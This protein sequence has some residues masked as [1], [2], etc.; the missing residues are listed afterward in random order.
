[1]LPDERI[2]LVG[3]IARLK[4]VPN[5][6]GNVVQE[7]SVLALAAASYGA[8]PDPN[9]T[10]PTGFDPR[11]VILF[12]AIVEGAFL[13]ASA[14]GH[15]DDAER[16]T[17]SRIVTAA[18]G[19]AVPPR[20]IAKLVTDLADMLH[21]DGPDTRALRI[22]EGAGRRD[23]ALEVIR[24]GAL[25]AD[26]SGGVAHAE[27]QVLEKLAAAAGLSSRDIDEALDTVRRELAKNP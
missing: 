6:L 2:D 19:G 22:A 26:A 21:E 10:S 18:C 12:E 3:R 1:M 5:E 11:A 17:F 7:R 23:H 8:K 25:I 13:V 24:I 27:R 16:E 4:H 15:F 9:G 14:D 20:R